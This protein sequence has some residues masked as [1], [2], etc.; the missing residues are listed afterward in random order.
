MNKINLKW[1]LLVGDLNVTGQFVKESVLREQLLVRKYIYIRTPVFST[2]TTTYFK[3]SRVEKKIPHMAMEEKW[4]KKP[5][6]KS[7]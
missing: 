3:G 2:T 4:V 6:N 7:T 1:R 5:K